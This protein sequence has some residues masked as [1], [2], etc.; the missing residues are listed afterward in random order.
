MKKEVYE[1]EEFCIGGP[2]ASLELDLVPESPH[3][4]R[5]HLAGHSSMRQ[6][7]S[8]YGALFYCARKQDGQGALAL[9]LKVSSTAATGFQNRGGRRTA[10]TGSMVVYVGFPQTIMGRSGFSK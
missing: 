3:D 5:W 9:K 2:Q 1:E 8:F 6:A 7:S 10:I 4:F